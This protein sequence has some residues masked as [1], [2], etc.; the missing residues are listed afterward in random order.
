MLQHWYKEPGEIKAKSKSLSRPVTYY[1][2]LIDSRDKEII[3]NRHP[4]DYATFLDAGNV[5]YYDGLDYVAHTDLLPFETQVFLK[6]SPKFVGQFFCYGLAIF[7]TLNIFGNIQ[8]FIPLKFPGYSIVLL[9]LAL[10]LS[11]TEKPIPIWLI[12][13]MSMPALSDREV[14]RFF[15]YFCLYFIGQY[16]N[17][18][19]WIW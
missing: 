18:T 15:I 12:H 9:Y 7:P 19:C 4:S 10:E 1:C 8:P 5:I 2:V 17:S 6:W 14:P 3:K 16:P 13:L 11:R